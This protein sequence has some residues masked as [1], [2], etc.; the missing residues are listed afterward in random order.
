MLI[1]RSGSRAAAVSCRRSWVRLSGAQAMSAEDPSGRTSQSRATSFAT[2]RSERAAI[3]NTGA[4]AMRS[5]SARGSPSKHTP[6]SSSSCWSP[7]SSSV[8]PHP[9]TECARRHPVVLRSADPHR[10]ALGES[11]GQALL[12]EM[13]RHRPGPGRRPLIHRDPAP[14]PGD[15]SG[16]TGAGSP[17]RRP[18]SPG[19]PPRRSRSPSASGPT[20]AT[21]R[22]ESRRGPPTSA[23]CG[24]L[25]SHGPTI[26][27][28]R[29]PIAA[30][31]LGTA[32]E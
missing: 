1:H 2:V 28:H 21:P 23:R 25:C 24:Y 27:R 18:A 13:E 20:S 3:S 14:R 6:R 8:D 15:R 22:Q 29:P 26:P 12:A 32:L 10:R 11:L 30:T 4:P 19:P 16:V 9:R 31:S 17:G 5:G 7:G